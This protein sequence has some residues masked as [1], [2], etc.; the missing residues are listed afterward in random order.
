MG[1]KKYTINILELFE[2]N[3][4]RRQASECRRNSA[5][6][7][8]TEKNAPDHEEVALMLSTDAEKEVIWWETVSTRKI[9]TFRTAKYKVN[10]NVISTNKW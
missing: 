10:M 1:E 2:T 4:S 7:R 8:Y 6:L 5:V 9:T 3:G